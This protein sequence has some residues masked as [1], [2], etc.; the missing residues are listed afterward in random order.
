[1]CSF[2]FLMSDL[3]LGV[4]I[5]GLLSVTLLLVLPNT[6][7]LRGWKVTLSPSPIFSFF[8]TCQ[9]AF[10]LAGF[11]PAVLSLP[12]KP[13]ISDVPFSWIL[14]FISVQKFSQANL[15]SPP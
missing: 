7:R 3:H 9:A 12:A 1:M 10:Q 14:A 2:F 4:M 15:L 6:S 8:V 11:P 13:R 5:L